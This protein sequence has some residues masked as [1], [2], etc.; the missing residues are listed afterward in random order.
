MRYG[1]SHE[2]V[3]GARGGPLCLYLKRLASGA[4]RSIQKLPGLVQN[5]VRQP[6]CQYIAM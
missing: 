3:K 5:F 4:L 6:E 1:E 2:G